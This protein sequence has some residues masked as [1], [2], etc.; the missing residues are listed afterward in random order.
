MIFWG[1]E[2]PKGN[3]NG[4]TSFSLTLKFIHNPSIFEGSFTHLSSLFFEFFNSSF[5]N[6]T[7]FI[8]EM[9]CGS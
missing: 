9:T 2:L 7:A 1:F 4:D 8:D 3:I 6:T 5:I